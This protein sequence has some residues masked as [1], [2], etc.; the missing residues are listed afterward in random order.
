M[1][2]RPLR[3]TTVRVFRRNPDPRTPSFAFTARVGGDQETRGRYTA[4]PLVAGNGQW[5]LWV[6]PASLKFL[7]NLHPINLVVVLDEEAIRKGREFRMRGRP[8]PE[9]GETIR[10]YRRNGFAGHARMP[11]CKVVGVC[12]ETI[13]IE[14]YFGHQFEAHALRV[15]RDVNSHLRIYVEMD[16]QPLRS[17]EIT[18]P[19]SMSHDRVEFTLGFLGPTHSTAN[20]AAVRAAKEA[21][22]LTDSEVETIWQRPVTLRVRPSQFARFMILR[23]EY[24]GVN[25]FKGLK[26]K[27]VPGE[28]PVERIDASARPNRVSF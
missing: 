7:P 17:Q 18:E 23:N 14:T 19:M 1:I 4:I 15:L 5:K 20:Q 27:L 26:A 12:E 25:D 28:P 24:G 22:G 2:S 3:G 16:E 21:L 6:S 9:I 11:D 8:A 10:V 13:T